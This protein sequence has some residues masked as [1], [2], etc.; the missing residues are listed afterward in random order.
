V[1]QDAVG[2]DTIFR[3]GSHSC[4]DN[5]PRVCCR[6]TA[7]DRLAATS[8][9]LGNLVLLWL[10]QGWCPTPCRKSGT[11]SGPNDA[12]KSQP[13]IQRYYQQCKYV[14]AA[15][16]ACIPYLLCYQDLH[17]LAQGHHKD[18]G[19]L[20]QASLAKYPDYGSSLC[21]GLRSVDNADNSPARPY[22]ARRFEMVVQADTRGHT[23]R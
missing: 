15:R 19:S 3:D 14:V 20:D 23:P 10:K 21:L 22:V 1:Y 6:K 4:A 2:A 5:H 17:D 18:R 8:K 13:Q 9:C 11:R 7:T 12:S 16:A